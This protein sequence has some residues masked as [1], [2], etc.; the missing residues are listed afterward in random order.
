MENQ[1]QKDLPTEEDIFNKLQ[2]GGHM[3]Y[4]PWN[5]TLSRAGYDLNVFIDQNQIFGGKFNMG[6]IVKAVSIIQAIIFEPI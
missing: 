4:G 6:N 5:V 3:S 2:N 1:I